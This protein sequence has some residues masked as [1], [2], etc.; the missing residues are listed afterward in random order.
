MKSFKVSNFR[1]FGEEGT[2]V[3]FKPVTVLTG[4]N[5]SGK[6][7]FVK[8]IRGYADYCNNVLN[9]YRRDGS[10]NPA[11]D[12]L[13]LYRPE[14]KIKGFS[15]VKNK[16][17]TD[18]AL[19]S[20]THSAAP[21]ASCCDNYQ[22]THSFNTKK[23]GV[24]DV[25]EL[26]SIIISFNNDPILRLSRNGDG[27]ST[28][29]FNLNGILLSDFLNY[30]K[31]YYLP[32][33]L[34][35]DSR[36]EMDGSCDPEYYDEDGIFSLEKTAKTERGKLLSKL[37]G[38]EHPG[39]GWW[40]T[41]EELPNSI[42][43]DYK[44]LFTRDLFAAINKCE[45]FNIVFYFPVLEKFIG[46]DKTSAINILQSEWECA[47]FLVNYL[48]KPA[49][50]KIAEKVA[51]IIDDFKKS[52]YDS[53]LDYYRNLENYVLENV[54]KGMISFKRSGRSYNFIDDIMDRIDVSFDSLGFNKR[55]QNETMFSLVYDI[56]SVWQ[57]GEGEKNE[58]GVFEEEDSQRDRRHTDGDYIIRN[59]SM[60][61]MDYSSRH[62]LFEAYKDFIRLLLND[63]LIATDFYRLEYNTNSFASVQR[64]HSFE[65]KSQFVETMK[66]YVSGLESFNPSKSEYVPNSFLNKWLGT[67]GLNICHHIE[68]NTSK[69]EGLGF[70]VELV[71][72]NGERE[73]L[74]DVGHGIT[75][76]VSIL[77]QIESIIIQNHV[78]KQRIASDR[79]KE[80]I[81]PAII[82]LEEPEVSLHPRMQSLLA[83]ILKDAATNYGGDIQFIL[84]THSEYLVRKIQVL[85]SADKLE[86]KD[87]PFAVYYFQPD[88][89]AYDMKLMTTGRFEKGF[90]P[91]FFDEAASLKYDLLTNEAKN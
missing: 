24:L 22:V 84:E 64:L 59:Y 72:E 53:F 52:E 62:V 81:S 13:D 11:Q 65:E 85:V 57:W 15:S 23:D 20:F 2:E 51:T 63:C 34:I 70:V 26:E 68:L 80:V 60:Q 44:H 36:N 27:F 38:L 32:Y 45:E 43:K 48:G 33:R 49:T 5:S 9:E 12:V 40:S 89:T 28:D 71:K 56:L 61:Y 79:T 47:D 10:F 35:V 77:I 50:D 39:L 90:G 6:S 31:F 74:A 29:Y 18:E 4:S 86:E 3:Q 8:A 30:C 41:V 88:G 1:L 87:I 67:D 19:V 42:F 16:Y 37:Q 83:D 73:Q 55:K 75:Q 17:A 66:K 78:L 7:S 58:V 76:I 91:G 14:L 21:I 54:N 46:K 82:M 69:V 25:G